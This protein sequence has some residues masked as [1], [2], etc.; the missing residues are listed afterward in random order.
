MIASSRYV[1][2]RFTASPSVDRT[3]PSD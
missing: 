1:E 2:R 3:P